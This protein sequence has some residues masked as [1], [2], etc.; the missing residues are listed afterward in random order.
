[1][2]KNYRFICFFCIIILVG[3]QFFS[4]ETTIE[5]CL[6]EIPPHWRKTF[7]QIDFH[8]RYPDNQWQ[9]KELVYEQNQRTVTI[10]MAKG[11]N[12]PVLAY[13]L[14]DKK[15]IHLPPAGAISPLQLI[16]DDNFSL[17]LSW[18][19]GFMAAIFEA[20][21]EQGVDI[22]RINSPRLAAEIN[23][24]A[25][26][27]PWK[28]DF[29]KITEKLATGS[30]RVTY[31]K[32]LTQVNIDILLEKGEWFWES[33]FAPIKTIDQDGIAVIQDVSIG[34][35]HLFKESTGK[36]YDLYVEED[37]VTIF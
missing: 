12:V 13:P 17:N 29:H 19:D 21:L 4:A 37:G 34:F 15:N 33:P 5:I 23:A 11:H 27:D 36:Y 18:E 32:R 25:A 20:L 1:M 24:E 35:H 10:S 31:I 30:F 6:P 8:I 26:G 28:L 2:L 14:I 3:C 7:N 22:T 16:K 9:M